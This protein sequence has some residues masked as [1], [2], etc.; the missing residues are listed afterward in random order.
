MWMD[1]EGIV[2]SERSQT[3]KDKN[4]MVSFICSIL[5][6]KKHVSQ[7]QKIEWRLPETEGRGKWEMQ[8]KVYTFLVRRRIS[9]EA[10]TYNL[11]VAESTS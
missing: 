1:L 7:K 2:L 6:G 11:K 5:K 4:C 8:V 3:E 10:L 9:S